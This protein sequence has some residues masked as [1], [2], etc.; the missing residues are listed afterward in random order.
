MGQDDEPQ[1]SSTDR[2]FLPGK[3]V[4]QPESQ[5]ERNAWVYVPAQIQSLFVFGL[6]APGGL[7]AYAFVTGHF[8]LGTLGLLWWLPLLWLMLLEIHKAG[9]VRVWI[10]APVVVLG[11]V[12]LWYLFSGPK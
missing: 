8:I 7:C 3:F 12:A 6:F 10:S 11:H 5:I 9:R 4:P 1:R 2:L